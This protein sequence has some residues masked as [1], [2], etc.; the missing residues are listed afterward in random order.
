M[1]YSK[2]GPEETL[3]AAFLILASRW[4]PNAAPEAI[5]W[6]LARRYMDSRRRARG[7][8]RNVLLP[9]TD[10]EQAVVDEVLSATR[11]VRRAVSKAKSNHVMRAAV[12][13][14]VKTSWAREGGAHQA[15]LGLVQEQMLTSRSL[16][17]LR[18]AIEEADAFAWRLAAALKRPASRSRRGRP[19]DADGFEELFRRATA[20]L[21]S[22]DGTRHLTT[23]EIAREI[24]WAEAAGRRV[25]R[26]GWEPDPKRFDAVRRRVGRLRGRE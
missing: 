10:D 16:D 2:W 5:G 23:A 22:E 12:L 21:L 18:E 8:P 3:D 4:H 20:R 24:C 25:R 26:P 11:G 6:P 19:K 9:L 7:G 13:H 14:F 15:P 1:A 17:Q